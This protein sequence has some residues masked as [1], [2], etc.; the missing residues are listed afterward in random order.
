MNRSHLA[1]IVAAV[2]LAGASAGLTE[3]TAWS[4]TPTKTAMAPKASVHTYVVRAGDSWWQIAHAHGTTLQHL[5]AA[6]H[7]T[8][9]TPVNAGAHVTLP[10]DAKPDTKASRSTTQTKPAQQ[11]TRSAPAQTQPQAWPKSK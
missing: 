2:V 10:A 5:L 9:S 4:K 3:G 8:T 6:N 7:A 11:A 1:H